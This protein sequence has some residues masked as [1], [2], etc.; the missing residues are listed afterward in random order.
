M[1]VSLDDVEQC[2]QF[3]SKANMTHAG[4]EHRVEEVFSTA[5]EYRMGFNFINPPAG[6]F[7]L[8]LQV[9]RGETHLKGTLCEEQ[10][11]CILEVV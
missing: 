9:L 10:N 7:Y 1:L 6:Y 4:D 5:N 2:T 3:F 11:V 8:G